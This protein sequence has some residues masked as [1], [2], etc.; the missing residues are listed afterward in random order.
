MAVLGNP[1]VTHAAF[2]GQDEDG[3]SQMGVASHPGFPLADAAKRSTSYS[4]VGSCALGPV[5]RLGE[6]PG[7]PCVRWWWSGSK[8][9]LMVLFA[10]REAALYMVVYA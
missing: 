6:P 8:V 4:S 9:P 7:H 5:R 3:S 2:T 10:K 1:E